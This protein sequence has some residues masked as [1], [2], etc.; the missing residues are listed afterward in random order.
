MVTRGRLICGKLY[1]F[2]GH[3]FALQAAVEAVCAETDRLELA[4]HCVRLAVPAP[5]AVRH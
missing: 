4:G 5:D 3:P 2:P 1:P